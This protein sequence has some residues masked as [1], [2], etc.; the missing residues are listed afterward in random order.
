MDVALFIKI[1]NLV[2]LNHWVDLLM[3]F[4]AQY[5][6]YLLVLVWLI[7][8]WFH[9]DQWMKIFVIPFL[10]AGVARVVVVTAIRFFYHHLRPV[11]VLNFTPLITPDNYYSFPSGHASV[12]FAM[13]TAL[14]FYNRR[15]GTVFLVG[16][17][18]NGLARIYVGVHWPFDILGGIITGISVAFLI[19]YLV[20]KNRST[21]ILAG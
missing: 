19:R 2:G 14:Y 9:R 6:P 17:L 1:H 4:L 8:S 5:L 16:A 12:F 18:L 10:A 20:K 21:E 13:A 11:S 3:I 7:Y 15:I